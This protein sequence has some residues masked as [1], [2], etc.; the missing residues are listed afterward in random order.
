MQTWDTHRKLCA[1]GINC[2]VALKDCLESGQVAAAGLD[3]FE[4]EPAKSNPLFGVPNFI[5][6]PHWVPQQQRHRLML[7]CRS[8]SKLATT[9]EWGVTK[10]NMP[11]LS[12]EEA[13]NLN[14]TWD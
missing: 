3:V 9:Y 14:H 1:W 2:E 4:T 13:P 10:H 12:A 11:S 8:P 7:P 6:T 5:C